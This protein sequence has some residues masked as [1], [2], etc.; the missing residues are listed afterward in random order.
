MGD[1]QQKGSAT[2]PEAGQDGEQPSLVVGKIR[3][4]EGLWGALEQITTCDTVRN[5]VL[6]VFSQ[7]ASGRLG[8]FCNRYLTGA[9]IDSSS[10][11]G[12]KAIKTLLGIKSGMFC[13]RPC[14]A[15]ETKELGQKISISIKE[16]LE[17]RHADDKPENPA[18]TLQR[19]KL[20]Q[21][22]T[23]VNDD[24]LRDV[25]D[26]PVESALVITGGHSLDEIE[27]KPAG[28]PDG[29]QPAVSSTD[30]GKGK[31]DDEKSVDY[32]DWMGSQNKD[33]NSP[34]LRKILLPTLKQTPEKAGQ[35]DQVAKDLEVYRKVLQK[36]ESKLRNDMKNLEST[37]DEKSRQA[38]QDMQMLAGLLHSQEQMI[39]QRWSGLDEIPTP[40]KGKNNPTT[41]VDSFGTT[42]Q[43]APRSAKYEYVA[44][45]EDLVSQSSRIT[46]PRDFI[47]KRSDDTEE[48]GINWAANPKVLAV[49]VVFL[50][51][52][53]IV[54]L[55]WYLNGTAARSVFTE[56][57]ED[58]KAGL[59]SDAIVALNAA[60]DKDRF[61]GQAYFYRGIALEETGETLKAQADFKAANAHGVPSTDIAVAQAGIEFRR[62][63]WQRTVEL[64]NQAIIARDQPAAVHRLRANANIHLGAFQDAIADCDRALKVAKDPALIAQIMADRG[65]AKMQMKD[66]Q[67][68]SA[69]FEAA[70]KEHP[71]PGLYILKGDASR[72]V[73][74]YTDAIDD[75]TK[76]L[77]LDP[78]NYDCYVARGIC[79][80]AVHQKETAMKDFGRALQLRP[81]GVE[82]LI[83]RGSLQLENGD[84]VSAI[85]DLQQ[86]WDLNP[87]VFETRQKL[88]I[89]YAK[90]KKNAPKLTAAQMIDDAKPSIAHKLPSDPKQLVNVGYS[91]MEQGDL[92]GAIESLTLAV[93][94]QPNN[95][96]ARRYLAHAYGRCGEFGPSLEQFTVLAG[97]DRLTV[98]DA[99]IYGEALERAGDS[100]K[101]VDVL[102]RALSNNP[103][104]VTLRVKLAQVYYHAGNVHQ[105]DDIAQAGLMR[106][107]NSVERQ[108]LL[109]T[110][111]S[112]GGGGGAASTPG[113]NTNNNGMKRVLT[114]GSHG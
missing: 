24:F 89:A 60:I 30:D 37:Q 86:A 53:I 80:A 58:V 71:E 3:K 105:G 74:R 29:G 62:E 44:G 87:T 18:D 101:A 96:N 27:D 83:R 102:T 1:I 48:I 34:N 20:H 16:V 77:G 4:D 23:A 81:N 90:L 15:D 66:F 40:T 13:F 91:L 82:A 19:I 35:K 68:G 21:V 51:G 5:G 69:D 47:K 110:M 7:E 12:V 92:D 55:A 26:Q 103:D 64:C 93:K 50:F 61:N 106:N 114:T 65:Y 32:L 46:D 45:C 59:F 9:V 8:V 49:G 109:D 108:Q 17:L 76:A 22:E 6:V 39:S 31:P 56:G 72:N 79:E 54:A 43:G 67:G 100:A 104:S 84:A 2:T 112:G 25:A 97:I 14:L 107:I 41:H 78:K 52:I 111:R 85:D 28:Q 99:A 94:K 63:Q 11:L 75:Y 33:D 73:K 95:A 10:E 36:E 57:K 113:G 38:L 70:I 42:M 98:D 88:M